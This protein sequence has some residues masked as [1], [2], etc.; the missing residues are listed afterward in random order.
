MSRTP[1]GSSKRLAIATARSPIS[2]RGGLRTSYK[3]FL[4]RKD[5][6]AT[7]RTALGWLI[8]Q[9][10]EQ[11]NRRKYLRLTQNG[12]QF[13]EELMEATQQERETT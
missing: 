11:E 9:V 5:R 6:E 12:R 3:V 13:I 7:R 4:D 2:C 8:R 10:D 1:I